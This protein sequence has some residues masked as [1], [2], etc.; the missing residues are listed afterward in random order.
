MIPS[1]PQQNNTPIIP[2]PSSLAGSV[3]KK[4]PDALISMIQNYIPVKEVAQNVH[5]VARTWQHLKG[6]DGHLDLSNSKITDDDLA[7]IIKEYKNRGNLKSL[8][9][10]NCT[11]I[12]DAGLAHLAG[13]SLTQLNLTICENITDAGLAHLKGLPLTQLNLSACTNI[14]DAGLAHLENL[15]LT[16]LNLNECR[17]ITEAGLAHLENLPL[18]HLNLS[19][20]RN[21]SKCRPCASG[22]SSFNAARSKR[23]QYHRR[24]PY[25]SEEACFNTARYSLLQYHKCRPC[26]SEGACFNTARSK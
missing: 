21:I 19:E 25:A 20:C 24:R 4:V 8:N 22:K 9:L 16:H 7:R 26:A 3:F 14:T 2:A 13:L 18:T 1:I 10:Y 15:P 11:N 23:V 12:T 6:N 5:L 17:N